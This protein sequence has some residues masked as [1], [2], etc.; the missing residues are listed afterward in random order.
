[1]NASFIHNIPG[2]VSS[3]LLPWTGLFDFKKNQLHL[4]LRWRWLS[5]FLKEKMRSKAFENHLEEFLS[6]VVSVRSNGY[7]QS[8]FE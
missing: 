6:I 7:V 3:I 8:A 5:F 1:M 4:N 2:V